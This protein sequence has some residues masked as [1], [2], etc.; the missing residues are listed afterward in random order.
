MVDDVISN[1]ALSSEKFIKEIEQLVINH[2]LDYMDA[3]VHFCEKNNVE[4]EVAA[5]IIRSNIRIKSKLQD[6][7]EELN[8]LPKRAKLPV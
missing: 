7:A 1:K 4:I 8:F 2:D 3:V 5:S 6:E